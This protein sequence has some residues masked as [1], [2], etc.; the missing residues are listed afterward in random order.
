MFLSKRMLDVFVRI[1]SNI[2]YRVLFFIL[3]TAIAMVC[4]VIVIALVIL[5]G[6]GGATIPP[7][8]RYA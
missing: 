1:I 2:V 7:C 4:V 8:F 6:Y 3:A 5:M